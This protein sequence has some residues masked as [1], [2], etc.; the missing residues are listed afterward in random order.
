MLPPSLRDWLAVDHL[1]WFV[2]DAVGEMDLAAF[3]GAYRADGWGRPAFDPQLMVAL[4]FYAYVVGERSSRGI[5]RRCQE[6]VAFRVVAANQ[7]PDHATIARFLV[8]H[9]QALAET[10]TQVLVLCARAG[11]VKVG[12]IAVDGSLGA[13]NASPRTTRSYGWL[14]EQVEEMLGEA[15]AVDAA[16]DAQYGAARGDEL[17]AELAEPRSRRAKLRRCLEELEAEQAADQAAADAAHNQRLQ[18]RA[19]R[20]GKSRGRPPRPPAVKPLDERRINITDPD[21]RLAKRRGGRAVQ[22]YNAQLVTTRQ[23][24]IVAAELSQA[25]N[26][27]N[28]LGPMLTH[29]RTTLQKAGIT[30]PIELVLADG[31]YW[32][33][34]A[35]ASLEQHGC[36]VLVPTTHP[37]CHGPVADRITARLETPEGQALYR[38]RQAMVE[39]VFAQTKHTRRIDRL[40]RRGLAACQ[41][42][43]KLIATTHNLLKLWRH[44]LHH[45]ANADTQPQ[46]A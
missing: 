43:W 40:R 19:Q 32:N 28:E 25:Q 36:Q 22:G 8:R 1:A 4:V 23:Q 29:T 5:E 18:E 34:S 37:R 33:T 13:G 14:R 30:E 42:E 38:H 12:E 44:N 15:I 45:A 21:T 6:D 3:R 35:I 24:V 31:G 9:E 11:L 16:E 39:P 17:P 20:P 7:T 27:W 2:V 41:A 46:T 26:D 10:L